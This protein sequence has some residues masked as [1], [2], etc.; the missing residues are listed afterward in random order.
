[1]GTMQIAFLKSYQSDKPFFLAVGF[2][3][4]YLTFVAPKRYWDL[5]DKD[6]IELPEFQ[7]PPKGMTEYTLFPYK[8]I[9]SFTTKSNH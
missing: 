2:T 7:K 1:M 9:E 8:E 4:P 5:Y 3:K 6:K